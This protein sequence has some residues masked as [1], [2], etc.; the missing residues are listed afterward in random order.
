MALLCATEQMYTAPQVEHKCRSVHILY[1]N[2]N[3][4]TCI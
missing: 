2:C 3:N 1:G 4:S